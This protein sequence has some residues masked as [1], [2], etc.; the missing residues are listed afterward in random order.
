MKRRQAKFVHG[1]PRLVPGQLEGVQSRSIARFV[2]ERRDDRRERGS[3][4]RRVVGVGP[5]DK[6]KNV[7]GP[8]APG[9]KPL[10]R[11]KEKP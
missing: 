3:E 10:L 6:V 2:E 8:G 4:R 5:H 7:L 1:S 9:K 11:K